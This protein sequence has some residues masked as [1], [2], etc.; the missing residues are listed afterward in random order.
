MSQL[1]HRFYVGTLAS[2]VLLTFLF[3]LVKGIPYYMTPIEE[4]FYHP[5]HAWFKPSGVFGHGLGIVNTLLILIGVFGYQAKKRFRWLTAR[6]GRLKYWLEFHSLVDKK[7]GYHPSKDVRGK[8]CATCHSDHHGRKFD[9]V[10]FDEKKFDHNLAGYKLEG[11][12]AKVDCRE[13]HKPDYV[14]DVNLKKRRETF[15]GLGQ[16][17]LDW[18][19]GLPPKNP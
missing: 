8:D 12:H 18:P 16:Q 6:F 17:C 11:A 7:W 10:R 4:R 5:D 14:D 3:L 2:I 19:H 15:L 9:M 1:A 13:C